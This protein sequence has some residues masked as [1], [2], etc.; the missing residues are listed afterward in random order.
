MTPTRR[1]KRSYDSTRRQ[2]QADATR[3]LVLQAASD[4]F[5]ERGY[6]GATVESIA[7]S[8]GVSPETIYASFGSKRNLLV[9]LL[10]L[11]VGGDEQSIPLLRRPGP[12]AVLRTSDPV[13]QLELFAEDISLILQRVS[14]LFEVVRMAAKTEPEIETLLNRMLA[15]RL[16]NM[17]APAASLRAHGGLRPGLSTARAADTLWTI[18]SPEVFRLLTVD[19]G[20][21]RE[22][23]VA[24]LTDT[25]SRLLLP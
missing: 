24:W 21:S 4:A 3:R 23:Y 13:R 8:A 22:K 18:T 1:T 2:A 5:A 9:A 17:Q 7:Q 10:D 15:E 19:R 20:W 25:L 12:Q 6:S 16:R 14:P 11:A